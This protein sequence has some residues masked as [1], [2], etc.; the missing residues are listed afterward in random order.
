MPESVSLEEFHANEKDFGTFGFIEFKKSIGDIVVFPRTVNY[1]QGPRGG[2]PS[3]SPTVRKQRL[4]LS[5]I[6][7]LGPSVIFE[8]APQAPQFLS[9]VRNA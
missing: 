3:D 2:Q 4:V 7:Q 9:E 8:K 5:E 6:S 1:S